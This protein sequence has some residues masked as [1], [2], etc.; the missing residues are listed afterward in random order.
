MHL[1]LLLFVL[2]FFLYFCP[3]TKVPKVLRSKGEMAQSWQAK[4]QNGKFWRKQVKRYTST[5]LSKFELSIPKLSCRT[6][7]ANFSPSPR[8]LTSHIISANRSIL[9]DTDSLLFL[10]EYIGIAASADDR[11][12]FV[13]AVSV[14]LMR[15]FGRCWISHHGFRR[16]G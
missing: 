1:S 15:C 2:L 16:C 7:S 6:P 11:Q 5:Q 14:T 3:E 13:I 12:C 9:S 4:E 8:R 10:R